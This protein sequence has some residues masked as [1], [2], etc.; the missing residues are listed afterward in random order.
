MNSYNENLQTAILETLQSQELELKK[1]KSQ[2]N[3]SIFTNYYAQGAVITALEKLETAKQ[4]LESKRV[5]DEQLV[6]ISAI[7]NTLLLYA[8]QEK[9]IINQAVKNTAVAAANVQ[10]ATSSIV[11]LA[12]DIGSVFSIINA[13][14]FGD[15][16][17]QNSLNAYELITKTAYEAEETSNLALNSSAN[18]AEISSN[19]LV[20]KAKATNTLIDNLLNS[21]T[22]ELKNISATINADLA[23]LGQA[24]KVEKI[25]EG[26]MKAIKSLLNATEKAYNLTNKELNLNLNVPKKSITDKKFSVIFDLLK[27][28]FDDQYVSLNNPIE[29]YFVLLV[30]KNNKS[31]FT[32][33]T[34]LQ[35]V[36]KQA[37]E[38]TFLKVNITD[39]PTI[40]LSIKIN[41]INDVDGQEIILGEQYVI[42]VLGV[43]TNAYK[44]A[45]N[46]FDDFL[47]VPSLPFSLT[48]T[49]IG[50]DVSTF[51]VQEKRI[52]ISTPETIETTFSFIT[53]TNVNNGVMVVYRCMFLPSMG[54]NFELL[55]AEQVTAGSYIIASPDTEN[56]QK[57]KPNFES[58]QVKLDSETTD[59][60]G[61]SLLKG[62][63]Y[64]PVVLTIA[65]TEEH[66]L[67]YYSSAISDFHNTKS[68]VF[69]KMAE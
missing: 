46:N 54:V 63:S 43:F 32:T 57:S 24:R 44:K 50:P 45:I 53:K 56:T 19:A 49:L 41:E 16:I 55:L 12:S 68:F 8:S 65:D 69:Q 27:N 48:Q 25:S 66:L 61:N 22:A 11:K 26:N 58:W 17:Y 9:A 29:D 60:F 37:K 36:F 52:I 28:P 13:S 7:S 47:S 34:A 67:S 40:E 62:N 2:K 6:N 1:V 64:I 59:V 14:D 38:K 21:I 33:A 23:L 42:F 20:E 31:T 10:I 5:V 51:E 4:E 30:K 18:M 39:K 35:I 15:E 3:A